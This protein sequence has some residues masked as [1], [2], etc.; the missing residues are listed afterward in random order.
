MRHIS[1]PLAEILDDLA[2]RVEHPVDIDHEPV[3]RVHQ[4]DLDAHDLYMKLRDL[5][6]ETQNEIEKAKVEIEIMRRR[7]EVIDQ[8]RGALVLGHSRDE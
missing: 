4:G 3:R 5:G 2:K 6:H 8:I 1:E 7:K